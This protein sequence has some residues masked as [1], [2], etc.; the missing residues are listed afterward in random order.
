[1]T[2]LSRGDQDPIVAA[3]KVSR[4]GSNHKSYIAEVIKNPIAAA[5]QTPCSG[6][7]QMQAFVTFKVMT[8]SIKKLV[9]KG[10]ARGRKELR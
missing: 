4:N 2:S 10:P 1:M 7:A 8:P 5:T 9:R 6:N 3:T